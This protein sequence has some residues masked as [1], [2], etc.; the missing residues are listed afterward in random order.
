MSIYDGPQDGLTCHACSQVFD[1]GDEEPPN[2]CP[3]CE[4]E[5]HEH[6]WWAPDDD[7]G[8]RPGS[9]PSPDAERRCICRNPQDRPEG[10]HIRTCPM[11]KCECGCGRFLQVK[12]DPW[13]GRLVVDSRAR[14]AFASC[15]QKAYKNRGGKAAAGSFARAHK[16]RRAQ[17]MR[18]RAEAVYRQIEA[19]QEYAAG[20]MARAYALE[21]EAA[22][23]VT[24][25]DAETGN[26]K[27]DDASS[28]RKNRQRRGK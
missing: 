25:V 27:S 17:Q 9:D 11:R 12:A 19:L 4:V 2:A 5:S 6:P 18:D 1:F 28:S 13:S 22:G 23:Q 7:D 26:W 16:L 10:D 24:L 20:F 15:R 3:A 21:K 8:S 14:F